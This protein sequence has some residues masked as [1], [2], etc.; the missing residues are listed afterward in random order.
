MNTSMKSGAVS[1]IGMGLRAGLRAGLRSGLLGLRPTLLT[2]LLS[3]LF[4]ACATK[5]PKPPPPPAPVPEP[6]VVSRVAPIEV[7]TATETLRKLGRH[8]ESLDRVSAPLLLSN[9]D[10]CKSHARNLL[11]FTAKTQYSYTAEFIKEAQALFNLGENL[12]VTNILANSGAARAG[13][14]RGDILISVE[15]KF[16]P[17]GPDAETA[18]AEILAPFTNTRTDVRL[19]ISRDGFNQ[20]LTVPLTRACSFRVEVGNADNVNSYAD[21]RRIM[22]TRGMLEY[23]QSDTELA[24]V[25]AKEIAHNALSHASKQR[26]SAIVSAQISNLVR[27]NPD[28]SML[29]GSA[30]IKPTPGEL[31][32]A[33][34]YLSL[35][36][37]AR[38]GFSIDNALNFWQ[39]LAADY[40]A[41]VLSGHTAIHPAVISRFVAIEKGIKEIKAKQKSKKPLLPSP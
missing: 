28:L 4:A 11:G 24:Y 9:P 7:D 10:L 18:A 33:A 27:L 26:S 25:I 29:I 5:P 17:G 32:A 6:V 1:G 39:Q 23:I 15:G 22:V 14:L 34:D 35:Y 3:M 19:V 2:V 13:L 20:S 30:G 40:P 37:L 21:G 8:Q 12:Q 36:M 16:L 31:D 41:S 38:A